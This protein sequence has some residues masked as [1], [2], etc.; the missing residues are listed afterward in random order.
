M[1]STVSLALAQ[2]NT[3][4]TISGV[5]VTDKSESVAGASVIVRSSSGEQKAV[6]DSEGHF[7][8]IVHRAGVTIHLLGK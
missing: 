6:T 7:Q 1:S 2:T 4:R 8:I 3:A 5:V